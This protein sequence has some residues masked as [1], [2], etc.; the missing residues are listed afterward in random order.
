MFAGHAVEQADRYKYLGVVMHQDG[1]CTGAVVSLQNPAQ[2]ALSA[3]QARCAKL[4]I[5]DP[6]FKCKLYDAV[7]RPVLSYSCEV[8]MPLISASGLR[9]SSQIFSAGSWV[10]HAQQL[11]ST[12][13][14]R[15]GGC[16]IAHSGGSKALDTCTT[17]HSWMTIISS[18]EHLLLILCRIWGGARL[19]V[20]VCLPCGLPCR[21]NP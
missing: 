7:V 14:L 18:I 1:S 4:S 20:H 11:H 10:Y 12:A 8:W 2:R 13:M 16:R 17:S 15:M 5:L 21:I 6:K 3:L 19:C 9:R